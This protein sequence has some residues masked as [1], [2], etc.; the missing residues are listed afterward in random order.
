[1]AR[2]AAMSMFTVAAAVDM[3][4]EAS[5]ALDVKGEDPNVNLCNPCFQIGGQG[6]NALLN[7]L[8][9]AG[10]VGGCGSLCAAALPAGGAAAVGCELVC[11]AVGVKAFIA[12]INKVDLDPIYF[13]EVLHACAPA[14]DDAYLEIVQVAAQPAIV[15]HGDDIQ[16]G[17]EM[18]VTNDTGVGEFSIS[19]DGPGTATPLS[20]SFFL[21]DGIPRG[22]QMLSVK[23]TL[24]DGQDEQGFPTTFE[25]GLYNF[26]FHVC[27]GECGSSHP[28]S[29][30]FGRMTGTFNMTG[31]SP[32]P[33]PSPSPTPAPDCFSQMDERS[34]ESTKD[35]TGEACQWC[36][37]FFSCQDSIMPC[38][39]QTV[40]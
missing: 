19:I 6:I 32:S 5:F 7:Y 18:N 4:L 27:Q 11:S 12:A 15:A 28:H 2:I 1:M 17:L 23:L 29:K 40:V 21:K 35:I 9:N 30:D 10:V 22:E 34:C 14:P 33:G 39:R 13:C 36:E 3:S 37:D 26:S 38:M 31:A 16:M 8:L 24:E 20:Q 25:P